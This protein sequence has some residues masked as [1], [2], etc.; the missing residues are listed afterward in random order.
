LDGGQELDGRIAREKSLV[1]VG[2]DAEL[3]REVA[4]ELEEPRSCDEATSVVRVRVREPEPVGRLDG[5]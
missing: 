3:G 1:A 2:P 5:F 4:E